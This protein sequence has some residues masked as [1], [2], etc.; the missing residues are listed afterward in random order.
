MRALAIAVLTPVLLSAAVRLP[1][2][3]G[4]S[5]APAEQAAF[6]EGEGFSTLAVIPDGRALDAEALPRRSGPTPLDAAG[7]AWWTRLAGASEGA[8]RLPSAL[9]GVLTAALVAF[10]AFRLAGPRAAAWA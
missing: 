4:P 8:L 9:A 7:L 10:L 3:G 6:V 5:L 2:L 1:R